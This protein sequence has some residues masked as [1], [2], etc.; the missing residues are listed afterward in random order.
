MI[1]GRHIHPHQDQV[2]YGEAAVGALDR[3][4]AGFRNSRLMVITTKSLSGP[5]GIA[6]QLANSLGRRCVG[7]FDGMTAH[8]PQENVIEG[9]QRARE[10]G[11]DLLVAV[12]GGSVIDA[13]KALQLCLWADLRRVSALSPYH[14]EAGPGG[15][16]PSTVA[17]T[18]RMVAIPTTLSAAEFTITATLANRQK[19]HKENFAHPLMI[20][21]AVILDPAM[22][23]RTPDELWY[24]T[25]IKAIDHAVEQLCN[26]TRAP[27]ADAIAIEG[28]RWLSDGLPACKASPQDLDARLACQF[29]MWLS[30]SGATGGRGRGAS[31]ALGHSLGAVFGVLHG[32][33]SCITLPAV[34]RWNAAVN[35]DR[36]AF[37][38]RIMGVPTRPA[39][40]AVKDLCVKFGLPTRPSSVGIGRDLYRAVAEDTMRDPGV[41]S[42][43]RPITRVEDIVEILDLAETT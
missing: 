5:D 13:V 16:D 3:L 25:G 26:P 4:A 23:L 43:P 27:F 28:L 34:L 21:R 20:P 7:V 41:R 32:M 35:R 37:I 19:G 24:S 18:V 36:Q 9:A 40:D 1:Q 33:T 11:A 12:G 42:N 15:I 10:A 8:S 17:A 38:S 39:A 6:T 29:G 31:H 14:T 22:G 2:V 30:I